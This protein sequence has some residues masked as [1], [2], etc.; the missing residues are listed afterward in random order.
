L[1]DDA[2]YRGQ[3]SAVEYLGTTQIVTL[4]TGHGEL[5]ARISSGHRVRE[6]ELV[7][8]DFDARTLS[9][10]DAESGKALL[11]EGNEGVLAHG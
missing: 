10:F 3:V 4:S 6:D 5:K 11:S 2:A 8:L 1:R 7:G 9:L